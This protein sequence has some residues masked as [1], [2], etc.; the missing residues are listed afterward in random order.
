MGGRVLIVEDHELLAQSLSMALRA[1]GLEV[2]RCPPSSADT[3]L[4]AV[5]EV[6]P[7][8]V[9]LDLDLGAAIGSSLPMVQPMAALGA[10]VVIVTGITERHRLGECLE[11]GAVSVVSKSRPFEDLV[12]AVHAALSGR[13]FEGYERAAL[14]DEARRYR[15]GE[16]ATHRV[17]ERLTPREREVLAALMDGKPAE[18]IAREA[19][20]SMST[21]RSQIRSLL[22]KLGTNSQLA[23]VAMARRSGWMPPP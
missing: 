5:G 15:E 11:A 1:D 23:A 12:A 16:R 4:A 9:L 18:Q 13:R 22:W 21:V 3:V 6:R 14:V 2:H 19:V 17:F 10:R 20:V 7:D 8:V